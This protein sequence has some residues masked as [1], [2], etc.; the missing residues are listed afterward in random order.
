[1]GSAAGDAP[2]ESRSEH[3]HVYHASDERDE[4]AQPRTDA[5]TGRVRYQERLSAVVVQLQV[6]V[7]IRATPRLVAIGICQW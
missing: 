6:L 4:G 2:D 1:M 7:R 5:R 3:D